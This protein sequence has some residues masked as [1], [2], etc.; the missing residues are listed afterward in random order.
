MCDDVRIENTGKYLLVGVYS[1]TIRVRKPLPVTLSMLSFWI[2][3]ELKKTD[4]GSCELR[5][6]DPSQ[7]EIACFR[8]SARFARVDEPGVLVCLIGPLTLARYGTYSVEFGL[9][10]SPRPLGTI[11]VRPSDDA[12]SFKSVTPAYPAIAGLSRQH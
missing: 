5:L 4:Y 7:Q 6:V 3:L 1:G 2:Q 10:C 9:G 11:A 12:A 8:S